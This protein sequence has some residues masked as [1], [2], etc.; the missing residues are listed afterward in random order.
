MKGLEIK[1]SVQFHVGYLCGFEAS[2]YLSTKLRTDT[3]NLTLKFMLLLL[4]TGEGGPTLHCLS[5]S[6]MTLSKTSCEFRFLEH[7]KNSKSGSWN[8]DTQD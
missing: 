4:A 6:E 3:K 5:L 1:T 7:M 8:Y 2:G